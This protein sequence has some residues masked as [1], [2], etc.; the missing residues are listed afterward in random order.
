MDPINQMLIWRQIKKKKVA[1]S[2]GRD[3]DFQKSRFQSYTGKKKV[4]TLTL[5]NQLLGVRSFG[6]RGAILVTRGMMKH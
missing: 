6:Q 1:K 2:G 3:F 5:D 4:G